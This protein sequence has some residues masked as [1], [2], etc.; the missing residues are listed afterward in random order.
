M[1]LFEVQILTQNWRRDYNR[2]RLHSALGYR[3]P[4]PEAIMPN[5]GS[6]LNSGCGTIVWGRSEVYVLK[7][8][9]DQT[10]LWEGESHER[11]DE[12]KC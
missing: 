4:V 9:K 10:I 1:M 3:P 2:V 7:Y 12:G 6:T 11:I 5:R 8:T